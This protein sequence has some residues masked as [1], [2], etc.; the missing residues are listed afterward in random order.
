MAARLPIDAFGISVIQQNGLKVYTILPTSMLITLTEQT[1]SS[2][3]YAIPEK[4][5]DSLNERD[6]GKIKK[7]KFMIT[8][9][10]VDYTNWFTSET[11][12]EIQEYL[13]DTGLYLALQKAYEKNRE[14]PS[15]VASPA[16]PAP[17][18]A[19]QKDVLGTWSMGSIPNFC[20]S[21]GLDRQPEGPWRQLVRSAGFLLLSSPGAL[22]STHIGSVDADLSYF[23]VRDQRWMKLL[24]YKEILSRGGDHPKRYQLFPLTGPPSDDT[25]EEMVALDGSW[26]RSEEHDKG[27]FA[28]PSRVTIINVRQVMESR[29]DSDMEDEEVTEPWKC[30]RI[31][32]E[33][34][35]QAESLSLESSGKFEFSQPTL[36]MPKFVAK[37]GEATHLGVEESPSREGQR[38]S[39]KPE[40]RSLE[41]PVDDALL[42]DDV[43]NASWVTASTFS[44]H[45]AS[46]HKSAIGMSA[47]MTD[48]DEEDC[49]SIMSE[50]SNTPYEVR[51]PPPS[52]PPPSVPEPTLYPPSDIP[53]STPLPQRKPRVKLTEAQIQAQR[54]SRKLKPYY[55]A[56]G[57]CFVPACDVESYRASVIVQPTPRNVLPFP[58]TQLTRET[59]LRTALVRECELVAPHKPP[60]PEKLLDEETFEMCRK[61]ARIMYESVPSHLRDVEVVKN[62]DQAVRPSVICPRPQI[63]MPDNYSLGNEEERIKT[64]V[65]KRTIMERE[66]GDYAVLRPG[67]GAEALEHARYVSAAGVPVPGLDGQVLRSR[68][69][70]EM[71]S[72]IDLRLLEL[73]MPVVTKPDEQMDPELVSLYKATV[74]DILTG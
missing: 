43:F 30:Q 37:S 8:S 59:V 64:Y 9:K 54:R 65:R 44:P 66:S 73:M 2:K 20:E 33:V 74:I 6:R 16:N 28:L 26:V 50:F 15:V 14:K 11:D 52:P 53:A 71:M 17:M 72:K 4:H 7:V 40:E 1:A 47:T 18:T 60:E 58:G 22:A 42:V 38:A 5:L 55:R 68:A 12:V 56:L 10:S 23:E 70:R 62:G 67:Y 46:Q 35:Q 61:R 36:T 32:E 21:V 13:E 45:K 63:S 57:D 49:E 31:V 27:L 34:T 48:I 41:Q 19:R 29:P 51:T 24:D 69:S 25:S 3:L 39:H